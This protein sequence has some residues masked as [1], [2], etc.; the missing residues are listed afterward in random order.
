M[1]GL[2]VFLRVVVTILVVQGSLIL[3]FTIFDIEL[4]GLNGVLLDITL[5]TVFGGPLAYWWIVKSFETVREE[6]ASQF[7]YSEQRF[8][9]FVQFS[10]DWFW[11]M[12]PD[13]RF[14]Y[15]SDGFAQVTGMSREHYL[16]KAY[17]EIDSYDPH[18]PNWQEHMET[19]EAHKP[20]K[21]FRYSATNDKGQ[22]FTFTVSGLPNS[23]E[24]G[25]FLGYWGASSDVT[26]QVYAEGRLNQEILVRKQAESF[27]REEFDENRLL[28]AVI[29]ASP[30]GVTISEMNG[31]NAALI[32]S[33][34]AVLELTGY[35]EEEIIGH[36]LFFMLGEET[37]PEVWAILDE[38]LE[39]S[40]RTTVEVL[41]YRKDGSTFWNSWTIFPISDAR[42][43]GTNIVTIN[44]DITERIAM[45]EDKE[46]MMLRALESS[47]IESLGTLAGGI[48]HE[49]NTP[50]QY[51][52]DNLVF[53]NGEAEKVFALL[54]CYETLCRKA[55]RYPDLDQEAKAIDEQMAKLGLDLNFLRQE[56][57]S[58]IS[59]SLSGVE[60]V[61][62]IVK[63]VKE[64]SHPGA[65]E[66][67][68]ASINQLIENVAVITH[69]QWKYFADLE[70]NLDPQL[71]LIDC[72]P[73]E[74]SQV[75]VNLII[76]AS[77]AIEEEKRAG[78][79]TIAITTMSS[80]DNVVIT[81]MDDGPGIPTENKERVFDLFFTSKPPG[82]GT[83]QGLAIS[84]SIIND[85][86]GRLSLESVPG[87]GVTFT[88]E[89]P[90]NQPQDGDRG[91]GGRKLV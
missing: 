11:E 50:I 36:D 44:V 66:M 65:K 54:D 40:I 88:I 30:I 34:K 90:V 3:I 47:K 59:Q 1:R 64:F 73:D 87:N 8:K 26:C 15:L 76:N 6:S 71:P 60:K 58:A 19:L 78:P 91:E 13:L 69:N 82:K 46:R 14:S 43:N 29:E 28:I 10:G 5:L 22:K 23:D 55:R 75:L 63:A 33:N 35:E 72:N 38:A 79:G 67:Q 42:G 83:G 61:A 89:L 32:Y 4:H 74:L 48:A 51:I 27:L 31:Q 21:N 62:N 85:H 86:N 16:G 52:G 9:D 45:Q 17:R 18:S 37:A 25:V 81:V 24:K 39:K 7:R 20:F 68:K 77:Q 56:V 57:P 84:H 53:L 49:I 41:C 80:G 2:G 70:T 12:G